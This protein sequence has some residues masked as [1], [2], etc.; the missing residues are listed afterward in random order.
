MP[1]AAEGAEAARGPFTAGSA[2]FAA[3]AA[4]GGGTLAKEST[5]FAATVNS[6]F[7]PRE[8]TPISQQSPQVL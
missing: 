1:E 6:P 8:G 4:A 3:A 7:L 5:A 2:V